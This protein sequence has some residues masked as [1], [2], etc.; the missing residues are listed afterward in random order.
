[1]VSYPNFVYTRIDQLVTERLQQL[2]ERLRSNTL[3][4]T[5]LYTRI[6]QLVTERLQPSVTANTKRCILI[7][8]STKN[9][10]IEN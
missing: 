2:T 3:R 1:M 4:P 9:Q 10:G 5:L 7:V 6:D 8:A